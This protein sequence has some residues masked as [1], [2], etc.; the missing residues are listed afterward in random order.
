MLVQL[1][2][3]SPEYVEGQLHKKLPVVSAQ[4]APRTQLDIVKLHS[5]MLSHVATASPL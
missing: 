4:K 3:P 2:T 5:L 1:V